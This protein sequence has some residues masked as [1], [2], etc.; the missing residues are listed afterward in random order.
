MGNGNGYCGYSMSNN[1]VRAYEEGLLPL[2]KITVYSLKKA[3]INLKLKEFKI[4]ANKEVIKTREWHHTSSQYNK[5]HFWDLEETQERYFFDDADT[6]K[7]RKRAQSLLEEADK[8]ND[9]IVSGEFV[10]H[11]RIS[12]KYS[13]SAV[14]KFKGVIKGNWIELIECERVSGSHGLNLPKKKKLDG[15]GVKLNK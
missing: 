13:K 2:S 12:M 10:Q 15:N 4:L 1:A 11:Q 9:K 7:M 6:D 3:G 14:F 8:D 5:T